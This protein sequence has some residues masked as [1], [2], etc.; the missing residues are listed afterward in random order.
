ME[1]GGDRRWCALPQG[2]LPEEWGGGLTSLQ[3]LN[4]S[5]TQLTG[6]RCAGTCTQRWATRWPAF[7]HAT[8]RSRTAAA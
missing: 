7:A 2:S 8:H 4:L 5:H 1:P 6:A 3:T